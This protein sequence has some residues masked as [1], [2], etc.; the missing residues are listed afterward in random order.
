M[1]NSEA[2]NLYSTNS[3]ESSFFSSTPVEDITAV[4]KSAQS[5]LNT[6]NSEIV[7][8]MAMKQFDFPNKLMQEHFNENYIESEKYPKAMFKGK[9]NE[10]IDFTKPGV[11]DV[12]AT[13]DFTIHG[14]KKARTLKGKLTVSQGSIS[15][16]SDFDVDLTDHDIKVPKIVFMKIAQTVRVKNSIILTPYIAKKN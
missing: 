1:N 15:I 3:G 4:N 9:I 11:Y 5:I 6:A 16:I 2:Q 14:V 10:V 13:G 8:Q 12:S 7:I